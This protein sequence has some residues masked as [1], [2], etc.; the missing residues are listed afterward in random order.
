[1]SNNQQ[2]EEKSVYQLWRE[3]GITHANFEF[4]CGGDS[5]NDTNLTLI[6]ANGEQVQNNEIE[7]YIDN[8][9]YNRVD[10]YVNSDGHYMGE[11]GTVEITLEDDDEDFSYCKSSMSEWQES[12]RSVVPVEFDEKEVNFIKERVLNINGSSDEFALNY[13]MDCI[14][15]DDEEEMVKTIEKKIQETLSRFEPETDNEVQDWYSFTT[16]G[17]GVEIT[18]NGNELLV[19]LDNQVYEYRD[20]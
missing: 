7:D 10:F 16:N 1:M 3:L 11:S 19:Q 6:G 13:K 4:S 20:E 12:F 5:M 17:E 8:E 15:T 18:F 2:Q 9:I 14:L